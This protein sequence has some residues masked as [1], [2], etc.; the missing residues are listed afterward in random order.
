MW[1]F[2]LLTSCS[3]GDCACAF[4]FFSFQSHLDLLRANYLPADPFI[5]FFCWWIHVGHYS[6][7]VLHSTFSPSICRCA[8]ESFLFTYVVMF[9]HNFSS[10]FVIVVPIIEVLYSPPVYM[11]MFLL[12]AICIYS[13]CLSKRS[14]WVLGKLFHAFWLPSIGSSSHYTACSF[15]TEIMVPVVFF[16]ESH[17][18]IF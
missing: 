6:K 10:I 11:R 9:Q 1:G 12:F 8:H 16:S 7:N 3:G 4:S 13:H 5:F 2:W 14:K 17:N 18:G 15:H